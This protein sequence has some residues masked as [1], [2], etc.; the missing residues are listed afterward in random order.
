MLSY[1]LDANKIVTISLISMDGKIHSVLNN[2]AVISGDH[3]Q[4]I[5]TGELEVGMYI[6]R[7][8]TMEHFQ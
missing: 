1:H 5:N 4:F 7:I 6:C 8:Q 2:E 3:T